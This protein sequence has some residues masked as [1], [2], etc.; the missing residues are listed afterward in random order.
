ML[1]FAGRDG[2]PVPLVAFIPVVADIAF[3]QVSHAVRTGI[4]PRLRL[5]AGG[6]EE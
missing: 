1:V 5:A 3:P 2:V 4:K 6:K